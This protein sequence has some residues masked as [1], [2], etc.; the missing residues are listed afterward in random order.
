MEKA[1]LEV[2]EILLEEY[3][4]QG[5]WPIGGKYNKGFKKRRKT[6]A[7]KL[8]IS[9]GAFLAQNT[10]W[11]NAQRAVLNLREAGLMDKGK[12]GKMREGE[13]ASLIKPAGYYNMKARKIKEFLKYSGEITREGLLS[14]WGCGEETADSILLYAYDVP[15][16]VADAYSRRLFSRLGH[17]KE[18]VSYGELQ[19]LAH[20]SIPLE[21]KLLNEC[22]ALIVEHAKRHCRAKPE[23]G[24]CPLAGRCKGK[25]VKRKALKRG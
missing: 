14:V 24:G 8:E 6:P 4:E 16:F 20:S 3:G 13:I 11:E 23:C 2:Y 10:S 25:G 17:C 21:P 9:I 18:G 1:I 7:E 15:V 5:W 12:L 19:E 22:H